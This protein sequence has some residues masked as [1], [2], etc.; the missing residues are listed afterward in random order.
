MLTVRTEMLLVDLSF[1]AL[2]VSLMVNHAR[3]KN[4]AYVWPRWTKICFYVLLAIMLGHSSYRM[5]WK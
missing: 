5:W 2:C 3:S 4:S 1:M